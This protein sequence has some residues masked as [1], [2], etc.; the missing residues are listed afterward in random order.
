MI[1]V[2]LVLDI[3]THS[4]AIVGELECEENARKQTFCNNVEALT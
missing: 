3:D 4:A 1:N 2:W